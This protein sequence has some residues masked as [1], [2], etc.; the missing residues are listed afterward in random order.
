MKLSNVFR[1]LLFGRPQVTLVEKSRWRSDYHCKSFETSGCLEKHE[2]SKAFSSYLD[3][4]AKWEFVEDTLHSQRFIL[5]PADF[6]SFKFLS[7]CNRLSLADSGSS[8]DFTSKLWTFFVTN[9]RNM[10]GDLQRSS[11]LCSKTG[12]A[13]LSWMKLHCILPLKNFFMNNRGNKVNRCLI[14]TWTETSWFRWTYS[15]G[16]LN[17]CLKKVL[18]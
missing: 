10:N 9:F 4:K 18:R 3:I 1:H 12:R 2:N 15:E 7:S 13:H 16:V 6:S 14:T 8:I 5:F 17:I 11:D